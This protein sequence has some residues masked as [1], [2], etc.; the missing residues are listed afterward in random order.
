M[1]HATNLTVLVWTE[2]GNCHQAVLT[3]KQLSKLKVFLFHLT[4]GEL[5]ASEQKLPITSKDFQ[6]KESKG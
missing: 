6:G 4:E 3:P 2:T 1:P 5:K